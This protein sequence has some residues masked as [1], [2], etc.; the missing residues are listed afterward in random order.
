MAFRLSDD[1]ASVLNASSGLADDYINPANLESMGFQKGLDIPAD[2]LIYPDQASADK[3]ID[4]I[5]QEAELYYQSTRVVKEYGHLAEQ[6][7]NFHQEMKKLREKL[8]KLEITTEEAYA[9]W[10]TLIHK[11]NSV[12]R[13]AGLQ[14]ASDV[15][16]I[17]IGFA[18]FERGL[19][20][21]L[22]R[23]T[24]MSKGGTEQGSSR[25]R[26]RVALAKV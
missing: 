9:Q 19:A 10:Q 23:Q 18:K 16:E 14:H 17:N 11:V 26:K 13:Q 2:L 22:Q 3:A 4:A 25:Q 15:E 20:E 6:A 7:N 21:K 1:L 12:K 8:A 24:N 5:T